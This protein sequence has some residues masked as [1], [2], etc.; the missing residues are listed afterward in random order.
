MKIARRVKKAFLNKQC[1]EIIEWK[2]DLI[3]KIE[4]IK[5]AFHIR[6][7]TIKD[8]NGKGIT[9]TK[10]IKKR[11][12]E[13]AELYKKDLSDP[14]NHNGVVTHLESDILECEVKWDLGSITTN[15][16]RRDDR[17][18]AELFKILNYDAVKMLHSVKFISL[19]SLSHV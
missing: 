14:D 6:M 10:D 15:K 9:E 19:H 16:A 12:Q 1:K 18:S 8:K 13:Y 17:I 4:D 2:R 5:G 3:K 11:W 7:D